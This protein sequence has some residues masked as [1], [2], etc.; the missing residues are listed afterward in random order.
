MYRSPEKILMNSEKPFPVLPDD[1][2][3]LYVK[4]IH[5]IEEN[6]PVYL[7]RSLPVLLTTLEKPMTYV[8]RFI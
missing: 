2:L 7:V 5:F 3:T 4:N 1:K 8:F 6:F